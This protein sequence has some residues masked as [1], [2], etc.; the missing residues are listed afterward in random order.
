M[1]AWTLLALLGT[2]GCYVGG[3][4][5]KEPPRD[6]GDAGVIVNQPDSGPGR[7]TYHED[8]APILE[9][10]CG[11]CHG[12]TPK[13][14][15]RTSLIRYGDMMGMYE[16][17][18]MYMAI[19]ERVGATEHRMPPPSQ[20]QL[21]NS[22]IGIIQDWALHGAPEGARNTQY[23]WVHDV[24]PIVRAKC[25]LCHNR[26]LVGGAPYPMVTYE[27]VT[28]HTDAGLA[29]YEVMAFRVVAPQNPMPPPSQPALTEEEKQIIALWAQAGAPQGDATLP[30]WYQD[31]QPI[32][33]AR[34][35][36]CH[37]TPPDFGA[38]RSLTAYAD[39]QVLHPTL[40]IP[41]HEVMAQRVGAPSS[42]MPPAAQPQ[43]TSTEIDVIK[44]WSAGGA[45]E[46]TYVPPTDG[47]VPDSGG[48][49]DSGPGIPWLDGGSSP[50]PGPGLRNLDTWARRDTTTSVPYEMQVG[51]TE[52]A[53]WSYR[54]GGSG[55]QHAV[56]FEPILDHKA[57]IHHAMLF[58]DQSG[59]D[60]SETPTGPFSCLGFPFDADGLN[61]ADFIA[62][63]FPGRGPDWL[64]DG[65]GIELQ[66]S[67]RIILQMHYD[68]VT[69]PG[70]LDFSGF[71][72]LIT[73]E[74][75]L[76]PAGILGSGYIWQTPLNGANETREHICTLSRPFTGFAVVPHMHNYGV[77]IVFDVQRVGTNVWQTITEIPAWSFDDQPIL[78]VP[79]NM[80]HFNAGDRLRTRCFWNTRG[81]TVHQGEGSQ[82]EMCFN[83]LLHYP[84]V[85]D[86]FTAC[87]ASGP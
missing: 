48:P 24:E 76:E 73:S 75:G 42:P 52:Y 35:A 79:Q 63:W 2:T 57:H 21:S 47:G 46:G 27:D 74:E 8:V 33:Q 7:F 34:C 23:T 37:S 13:F 80:Q 30:T 17:Q 31:V 43:L 64:P 16:G 55:P 85:P 49:P 77:R 84:L 58:L 22:E 10:R 39:T 70:L 71:R 11:L 59:V 54:V 56:Y 41:V 4:P 18:P 45:L 3:W 87:V 29:L 19:S 6:P 67:D 86:A 12:V 68:N 69:E 28:A 51:A 66:P 50:S 1:R 32:V 44:R 9:R 15:A 78:P 60:T 81:N 14:A 5:G 38:P 72:T 53:C 36:L 65:V 20:P 61:L 83:F 62:G 25:Q 82:D 26:P 40:N